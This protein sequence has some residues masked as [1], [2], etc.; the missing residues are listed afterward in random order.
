M[1]RGKLQQTHHRNHARRVP[2]YMGWLILWSRRAGQPQVDRPMWLSFCNH[3]LYARVNPNNFLGS[4][5]YARPP[6]TDGGS[7]R[8]RRGW[9]VED[10]ADE[11]RSA[12]GEAWS[13]TTAAPAGWSARRVP[14]ICICL[15]AMG[16]T[17]LEAPHPRRFFNGR[18]GGPLRLGAMAPN[19]RPRRRRYSRAVLNVA[20][21]F[22]GSIRAR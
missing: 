10:V 20:L 8:G 6:T 18:V 15:A 19:L 1:R 4:H 11:G 5:G 16:P 12:D 21:G 17:V 14:K 9:R 7:G 3:H 2:S 13:C 22:G